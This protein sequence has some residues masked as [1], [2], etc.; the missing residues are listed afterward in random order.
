MTLQLAAYNFFG[1]YKI[2]WQNAMA[3]VLLTITPAII[4]YLVLQRHI[5]KGMVAGA[6]KGISASQGR[7]MKFTERLL[8]A[9]GRRAAVQPRQARDVRRWSLPADGLCALQ[10]HPSPGGHPEHT[11]A[12]VHLQSPR[13]QR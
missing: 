11:A 5:I 3:G 4:F 12:H 6:V 8:G 2:E 9:Q 10:A 7:H 1:Q 13:C